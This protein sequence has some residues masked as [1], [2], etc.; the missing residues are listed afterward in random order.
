MSQ[1]GDINVMVNWCTRQK[2][3]N[4]WQNF[5][6]LLMWPGTSWCGLETRLRTRLEPLLSLMGA[7]VAIVVVLMMVD[8]S[9]S[10]LVAWCGLETRP[11]TLAHLEPLSSLMG[12]TV[13]VVAVVVD[14][15][16]VDAH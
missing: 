10:E 9:R 1:Y 16:V 12:A 8:V 15:V 13:A 7:M 4:V 6:I 14:L 2:V 3:G 11:Q 5:V